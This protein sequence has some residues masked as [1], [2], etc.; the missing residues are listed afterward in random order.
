V[1]PTAPTRS[2]PPANLLSSGC[3]RHRDVRRQQATWPATGAD[4]VGAL[5]VLVRRFEWRPPEALRDAL[6]VVEQ[7]PL[8][9]LLSWSWVAFTIEVDN[10]VEAAGSDH[11]KRL[12][13]ISMAMWA[14]GLRFIEEDGVTVDELQALAR[15]R[16]NIGGLERWGWISVGDAGAERREGYGS[17]RGVKGSTVL[18][19]TRAGSYARRLWPRTI[20]TVEERWRGRFGSQVVGPLREVLSPLSASMPWAPP[21]VHP[22]DGFYSHVIHGS[23]VEEDPPLVSLMGQAL[24]SLTLG[25]EKEAEVSLPM[26]ANILRVIGNGVLRKR[27]IPS[28]SGVSKEAVAMAINFLEARHMAEPLPGGSVR[29]TFTGLD[30]LDGSQERAVHIQDKKLRTALQA[31]VSQREALAEGLLPP[32]GVWRGTKPYLA[33]TQRLL[34]DPT[35]ALPWQP[36]VL[37]RGG[38]PDG[39]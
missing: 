8:T 31:V 12:F 10:A 29:L 30:A 2:S 27:D 24:T 15:A 13:R 6:S 35:A 11:L 23:E 3:G 33:Q 37:H 36:M 16:C 17:H 22:S 39:A 32:R 18:R 38:W 19:P 9:T 21:E 5:P 4:Q 28:L 20:T 26:G 34:A 14:N 1:N 25:Q 7:V